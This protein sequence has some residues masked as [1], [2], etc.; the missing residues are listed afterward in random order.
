VT[1]PA[2][3]ASSCIVSRMLNLP[4]VVEKLFHWAQGTLDVEGLAIFGTYTKG[5][6]DEESDVSDPQG[7]RLW[8]ARD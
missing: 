1:L 8:T 4:T 6:A 5:I 7:R 2:A 3:A